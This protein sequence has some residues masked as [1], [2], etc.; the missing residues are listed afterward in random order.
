MNEFE[1]QVL[2]DLASLK[3][4]MKVLLGNGQPGR[5]R[6]LEERVER[7][8]VLAQRATGVGAVIGAAL[9]MFHLAIDYWK[10][11]H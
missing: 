3:A 8:E 7:H 5:L 6:L 4:E 10:F 1:R 11:R 9:T 2:A